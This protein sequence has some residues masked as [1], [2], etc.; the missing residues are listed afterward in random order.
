MCRAVR[1][2]EPPIKALILTSYNDDE[3]LFAAIMAG[4]S[5][6][7]LEEIRSSDLLDCAGSRAGP[8]ARELGPSFI[9]QAIPA[10]RSPGC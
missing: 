2:V 8:E 5:G 3:A 4:D 7:V 6:Y 10:P 9:G 1:A